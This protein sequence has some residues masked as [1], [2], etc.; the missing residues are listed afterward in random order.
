[1]V[2]SWR[3]DFLQ[4]ELPA[5]KARPITGDRGVSDKLH[6]ARC[7]S[8][9]SC[10]VPCGSVASDVGITRQFAKLFRGNKTIGLGGKRNA[11]WDFEIV[12]NALIGRD[13]ASYR[14]NEMRG[15][16]EE[17]PH[18]GLYHPYLN[19]STS[20]LETGAGQWRSTW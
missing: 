13:A 18:F 8:E 16:G 17:F 19:N 11:K 9:S 1:M 7:T 4:F 20:P 12:N 3:D 2:D 5:S 10:A 6:R 15:L 14:R